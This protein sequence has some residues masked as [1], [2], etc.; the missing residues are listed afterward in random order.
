MGSSFSSV[1]Q[2]IATGMQV[3]GVGATVATGNPMF[4]NAATLASGYN[5]LEAGKD[6]NK[7]ESFEKRIERL[8]GSFQQMS[9]KKKNMILGQLL[10]AATKRD[11]QNGHDIEWIRKQYDTSTEEGVKNLLKQNIILSGIDSRFNITDPEYKK[12]LIHSTAGIQALY[13]A[14][15]MR[16]ISMLP[17]ELAFETYGGPLDKMINKTIGFVTK[18]FEKGASRIV[19]EGAEQ[20]GERAARTTAE[21]AATSAGKYSNGFR[22]KS[23]TSVESFRSGFDSGSAVGASLGFGFVGSVVTGAAA[24]T[25]NTA[26]HLAKEALPNRARTIIDGFEEVV[27]NKY[28]KVYDKLLKDRE[29]LSLAAK[30]GY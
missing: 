29:W 13:E 15:N 14:D 7:A 18:P 12:A 6:E 22:R 19:K 21:D 10:N 23:K 2:A 5:R 9:P 27:A 26:I 24:G 4:M 8:Y 25:A 30:Y 28:M 11:I 16:T 20:T 3:A 1:N 17:F